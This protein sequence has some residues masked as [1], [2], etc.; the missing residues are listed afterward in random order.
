MNPQKSWPT[1]LQG[2]LSACD[3]FLCYDALVDYFSSIKRILGMV[4]LGRALLQVYNEHWHV[5]GY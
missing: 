5:H 3:A 4:K 2:L 1:R